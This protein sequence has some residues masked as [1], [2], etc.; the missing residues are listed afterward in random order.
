MS[1]KLQTANISNEDMTTSTL[2]PGLSVSSLI[3]LKVSLIIIGVMGILTNGLV[4][5]GL[6]LAGRSKLNASSAHI[7][8]HT[9]FELLTSVSRIMRHALYITGSL[10]Y[11]SDS[12]RAGMALCTLIDSSSVTIAL[13][14]GSSFSVVIHTLDRFWKIVYPIHHRKHYRRWML[15]VALLLPWLNGVASNIIPTILTTRIVNGICYPRIFWPNVY[16]EEVCF[17]TRC[18]ISLTKCLSSFVL[19]SGITVYSDY[20]VPRLAQV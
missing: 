20:H 14:Q 13:F 4:L 6:G 3:P 18:N 19:M 16:M 15:Y 5:I 12:G 2:Q 10:N 9:A 8:N 17:F 7:A 11:Y 1:T